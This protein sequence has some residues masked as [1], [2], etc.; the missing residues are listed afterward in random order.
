MLRCCYFSVLG[1]AWN[2]INGVQYLA[3]RAA[4]AEQFVID[5][6]C[7]FLIA[8]SQAFFE[9]VI[10]TRGHVRVNRHGKISFQGNFDPSTNLRVKDVAS[11]SLILPVLLGCIKLLC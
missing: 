6:D 10:E 1:V 9:G 3:Y 8:I 7:S 2:A 4:Q 5:L 11:F